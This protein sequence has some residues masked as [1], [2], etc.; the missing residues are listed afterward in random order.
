MHKMG[1]FFPEESK[2]VMFSF[3]KHVISGA[4]TLSLICVSLS[5]VS[6]GVEEGLTFLQFLFLFFI[7][8]FIFSTSTIAH[9]TDVNAQINIF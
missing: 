6:I 7:F 3:L 1:F 4:P 2:Y 9:C 8:I 5:V